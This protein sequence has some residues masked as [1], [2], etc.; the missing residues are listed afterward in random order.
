M[1]RNHLLNWREQ[2]EKCANFAEYAAEV[3]K[4]PKEDRETAFALWS[5][6]PV[7]VGHILVAMHHIEQARAEGHLGTHIHLSPSSLGT[8]IHLS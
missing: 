8:H 4:L 5:A 6:G 7:A 1:I 3:V 2:A